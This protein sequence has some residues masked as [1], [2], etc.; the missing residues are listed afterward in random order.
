ME[1]AYRL[2]CV[3]ISDKYSPIILFIHR[4]CLIYNVVVSSFY[5]LSA[6]YIF[7]SYL[8]SVILGIINIKRFIISTIWVYIIQFLLSGIES[9][10]WAHSCFTFNQLYHEIYKRVNSMHM[11]H[12][13][14]P[15]KVLKLI[16]LQ[17]TINIY[18]YRNQR[19]TTDNFEIV[20]ALIF[21]F[22]YF[23]KMYTL[24]H[25]FLFYV[26]T[27]MKLNTPR[28]PIC[29]MF[30]NMEI[31]PQITCFLLDVGVLFSFLDVVM[32]LMRAV[33]NVGV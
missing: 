10:V 2:S 19:K 26:L 16:T 22:C 17:N 21:L 20:Q 24:V 32:L 33:F 28:L 1:A 18:R 7:C 9:L 6:I 8:I 3:K 25:W 12:I 13:R 23:V 31:Y 14:I 30:T 29:V 5:L 4:F 27:P 15:V 11:A